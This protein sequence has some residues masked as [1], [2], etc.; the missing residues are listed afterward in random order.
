MGL[1]RRLS[2]YR[3]RFQVNNPLVGRAIELFGNRVRMDGCIYSVNCSQ[4]STSHKSTL[5]F[6]LHEMDERALIKKWLPSGLPVLEFGGGLGVVSCLI[7]RKLSEPERHVV[8]EANPE[9]ITVLERNRQIN[10]CKFQ[11]YFGAICYDMEHVNLNI[12]QSFVGSSIRGA[13]GRSSIRVRATNVSSLLDS[14]GFDEAGIVCDI[15][16]VEADIIRRELPIL[17]DRIRFFMAEMH[18]KILG[19]R[20]VANLLVDLTDLGFVLK[21]RIGDSV[22]YARAP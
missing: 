21:E 18:P 7:N 4:I 13:V 19:D 9:M 3:M 6:G 2:W 14:T 15:E 5:A 1:A 11:I 22:F 17:G 12:D 8:V 20:V 10:D 16:G